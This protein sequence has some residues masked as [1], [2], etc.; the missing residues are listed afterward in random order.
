MYTPTRILYLKLNSDANRSLSGRGWQT[1]YEMVLEDI[2]SNKRHLRAT[3]PPQ[4]PKPRLFN[5]LATEPE[6]RYKTFH[7]S[8]VWVSGPD[9]QSATALSCTH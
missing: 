9:A 1:R 8:G 3:G 4:E 5:R 2:R 7:H 6:A